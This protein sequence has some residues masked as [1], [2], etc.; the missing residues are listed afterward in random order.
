MRQE[1]SLRGLARALGYSVATLSEHRNAGIF[2]ALPNGKYDLAAVV[3]GLLASTS[4]SAKH[5]TKLEVRGANTVR[6]A[7]KSPEPNKVSLTPAEQAAEDAAVA[8]VMDLA[9]SEEVLKA[10]DL[11]ACLPRRMLDVSQRIDPVP[12]PQNTLR[13]FE[14]TVTDWLTKNIVAARDE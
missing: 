5:R 13:G 6:T 14:R 4:P 9:N 12:H 3:K 2:R 8:A 7:A 10:V 1:M 11:L